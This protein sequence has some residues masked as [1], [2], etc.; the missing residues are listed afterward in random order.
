LLR[1]WRTF[2]SV[3]VSFALVAFPTLSLLIAPPPAA[4][5]SASAVVTPSGYSLPAGSTE[6]ASRDTT[7]A[8]NY[9]L[10]DGSYYCDLSSARIRF[11]TAGGAWQRVDTS[12]IPSTTPGVTSEKS[13][14][15]AVQ[16]ANASSG[17]KPLH[18]AKSGWTLDLE[19]LTGTVG[20]QVD[21]ANQAQFLSVAQD[22]DLDYE[23][24]PDSVKET[25]V[26]HSAAAPSSF[27]F[28]LSFTGLEL[29]GNGCS[30]ALY[31]PGGFSPELTLGNLD[32]QDSA[33]NPVDAVG[34]TMTVS[35]TMG[36]A[37]IT[38]SIPPTWLSDPARVFPVKV[39]PSLWWG[40]SA[41]SY[42][43]SYNKGTNNGTATSMNEGRLSSLTEYHA[44]VKFDISQSGLP[45]NAWP[46]NATL[47]LYSQ[48]QSTAQT[49]MGVGTINSGWSETGVTWNNEPAHTQQ[50]TMDVPAH[51]AVTAVMA[52][53]PGITQAVQNWFWYWVWNGTQPD[54]N[55]FVLYRTNT[56]YVVQNFNSKQA[57]SYQPSLGI[58]YVIPTTSV[59]TD[60]STVH[61]D[62]SESVNATVA[63]NM[64][65]AADLPNISNIELDLGSYSS[66]G[67]L[68]WA[69][70]GNAVSGYN[71]RV[72]P[73]G[74]YWG[75]G[76]ST[77][78]IVPA[79][80]QSSVDCWGD[81][82][83]HVQVQGERRAGGVI[84]AANGLHRH[85]GLRGMAVRQLG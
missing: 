42:T 35:P 48:A 38:Y 44:L 13:N 23:S 49:A 15:T 27:S 58:G 63:V 12:L 73:T 20:N 76:S 75:V 36:G 51:S 57:S 26:L 56:P 3:L 41:D 8:T 83:L 2:L 21:V 9:R 46:D 84:A 72:C 54:N 31:R 52:S 37:I 70:T 65:N 53:C 85:W 34:A 71:Y 78:K 77:T 62:G 22:T 30:W 47:K 40:A 5:A 7:Y 55:G 4:A 17:Y 33:A 19:P 14:D 16:F 45:Q 68:N 81:R 32:V 50:M 61:A 25:L 80:D 69:A 74:G 6:V 39:D 24:G 59:T 29:R 10:P 28:K 11:K 18:L 64:G 60:R 67:T 1:V 43:D 82:L 79:F 66:A